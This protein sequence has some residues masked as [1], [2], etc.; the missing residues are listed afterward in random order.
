[1]AEGG[2]GHTITTAAQVHQG[3]EERQLLIS[4]SGEDEAGQAAVHVI[5]DQ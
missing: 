1:M 2:E 3:S 5:D 4:L